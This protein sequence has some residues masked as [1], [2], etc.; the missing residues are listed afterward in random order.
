MLDS[1]C[2]SS[3]YLGSDLKKI[4]KYFPHLQKNNRIFRYYNICKYTCPIGVQNLL[5]FQIIISLFCSPLHIFRK[6]FWNSYQLKPTTT[7]YYDSHMRMLIFLQK[8]MK[9]EKEDWAG[10]QNYYTFHLC[11]NEI[12]YWFLPPPPIYVKLWCQNISSKW[13]KMPNNAGHIIMPRNLTL[14]LNNIGKVAEREMKKSLHKLELYLQWNALRLTLT[15]EI[16]RCWAALADGRHLTSPKI[17]IFW[18]GCSLPR[19]AIHCRCDSYG[20]VQTIYWKF[21]TVLM[22]YIAKK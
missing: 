18:C 7:S 20:K 22:Y 4:A 15:S 8:L 2:G 17:E 16:F 5:P 21:G 13:P 11:Q 14:L 10:V 9:E 12:H 3:I 19:N 6:K 1:C